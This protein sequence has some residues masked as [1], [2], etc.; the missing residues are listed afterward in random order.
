MFITLNEKTHGYDHFTFV[1]QSFSPHRRVLS[2]LD[3]S[4]SPTCWE[5]QTVFTQDPTTL[6]RKWCQC[7][8]VKPSPNLISY[9]VEI[10]KFQLV[11][12]FSRRKNQ[13]TKSRFLTTAI[14]V[15]P[16]MQ[17]LARISCFSLR[18]SNPREH[19][20]FRSRFL[21]FQTANQKIQ[22]NSENPMSP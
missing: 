5:P 16:W 2:W 13:R 11:C 12:C 7:F 17:N 14:S 10:S 15:E 3:E 20:D 4:V 6:Q 8:V 18:A 19:F 1:V 21:C 22:I 9:P